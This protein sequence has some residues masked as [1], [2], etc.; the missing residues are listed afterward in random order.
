MNKRM[1]VLLLFKIVAF[2]PYAI[3]GAFWGFMSYI[4]GI[5]GPH[6]SILIGL[7]VCLGAIYSD[8]NDHKDHW[9]LKILRFPFSRI[10]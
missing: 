1:W 10:K 2:I 6:V 9:T 3:G 4:S 5:A 7:T 8:W